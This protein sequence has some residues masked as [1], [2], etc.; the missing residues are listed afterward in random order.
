MGTLNSRNA[1]IQ[2]EGKLQEI[3]K[4]ARSGLQLT[5]HGIIAT[6]GFNF[7]IYYFFIL[8][9]NLWLGNYIVFLPGLMLLAVPLVL[10][11]IGA[12]NSYSV[13][14]I[15]HRLTDKYWLSLLIEGFLVCLSGFLLLILCLAP[16]RFL[17]GPQWSLPLLNFG[18]SFV[19]YYILFIPTFGYITKEVSIIFFTEIAV[20]K[21]SADK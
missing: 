19:I 12:L 2:K 13:K 5:G 16:I 4:I 6:F 8:E 15:Y 7:I 18:W 14:F 21:S 9:T 20:Q 1:S 17:F 10:I 3:I 11:I